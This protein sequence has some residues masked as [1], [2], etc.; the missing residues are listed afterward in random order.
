VLHFATIQHTITTPHD[1]KIFDA[2]LSREIYSGEF[3][4]FTRLLF[5]W[6]HKKNISQNKKSPV[7][8]DNGHELANFYGAVNKRTFSAPCNANPHTETY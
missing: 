6:Y 5:L 4:L 2:F 8:P 1:Y 7:R 3:E